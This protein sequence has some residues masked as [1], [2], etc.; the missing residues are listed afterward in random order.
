M[1]VVKT[2]LRLILL[3]I[4]GMGVLLLLWGIFGLLGGPDPGAGGGDER[5][6]LAAIFVAV[7]LAAI[8]VA[9]T[10]WVKLK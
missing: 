4:G 2:I 1:N 9:R 3:L 5:V 6:K 8:F 10:A 7:G